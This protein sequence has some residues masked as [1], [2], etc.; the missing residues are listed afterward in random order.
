MPRLEGK[1]IALGVMGFGLLAGLLGAGCGTSGT[2]PP[3]PQAAS[4]IM[5]IG[6]YV[7]SEQTARREIFIFDSG[8][9]TFSD[10][11]VMM[12]ESRAGHTATLVQ[13]TQPY[14]LVAGGNDNHSTV[15]R[16]A[17][18][19]GMSGD[20]VGATGIGTMNEARDGHTATLLADGKVLIAGGRNSFGGS[21]GAGLN[22]AEIF[23][24]AAGTFTPTTDLGGSRMAV[25][26]SGHTA[27]LIED[28]TGRVL[29]AGGPNT[30]AE[31]FDPM[32]NTFTTTAA[33]GGNSM[34]DRRTL[35][36]ATWLPGLNQ[37]LIT[38][39]QDG[40]N[41]PIASV[42]FFDP[43][44]SRFTRA[45]DMGGQNME[46]GRR[47]HTATNMG[48]NVVL[49]T[50]GFDGIDAMTNQRAPT[51]TAENFDPVNKSFSGLTSRMT[52]PRTSHTATLITAGPLTG[53]ALLYGG[54]NMPTAELYDPTVGA[55]TDVPVPNGERGCIGH[56]ATLLP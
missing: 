16:T 4:R 33:L 15:S 12:Q 22:T 44:T 11:P 8:T 5:I 41:N 18:F 45:T 34:H 53:Q 35:H 25:G 37:V 13:A 1:Q 43:A 30:D 40:S 51:N 23:D 42:E 49:I 27:T 50:G 7:P 31:I 28:G 55:F 26:R 32:H 56:T 6:G 9:S 36:R 39:G 47:E 52:R 24:P 20:P 54:T 29:I 21:A 10:P 2:P 17:E 19:R 3:P 46:L 38:G 14:V 48:L